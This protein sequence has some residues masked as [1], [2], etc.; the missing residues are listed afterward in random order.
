MFDKVLGTPQLF[1]PII[2]QCTRTL[3]Q[4]LKIRKHL[5]CAT[6][7]LYHHIS[8]SFVSAENY[9]IKSLNNDQTPVIFANCIIKF[10]KTF[11][12]QLDSFNSNPLGFWKFARIRRFFEL[13]DLWLYQCNLGNKIKKGEIPRLLKIRNV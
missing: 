6:Y 10:R 3:I 13:Q 9:F 4:F 11:R 12:L 2:C 7:I 5:H 8:S 1:T